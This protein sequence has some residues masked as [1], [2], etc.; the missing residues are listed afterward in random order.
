MHVPILALLLVPLFAVSAAFAIELPNAPPDY[1]WHQ[2][3]AIKGAFLVPSGWHVREES[4]GSTLAIFIT[5]KPFEP[6]QQFET[7]LSVN[8]FR[9]TPSAPAQLKQ[10]LDRTCSAHEKRLQLTATPPFALMTCEFDSPR[11]KDAESVRVFHLGIANVDTKTSYL[12]FGSIPIEH[13]TRVLVFFLME[14]SKGIEIH[15]F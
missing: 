4:S 7:G 3:P 13:K 10:M 1:S 9:D 12:V 15:L 5:A 6:P 11:G 8:V 2:V 14:I